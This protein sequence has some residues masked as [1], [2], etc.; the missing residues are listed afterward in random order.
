MI[1]AY[2]FVLQTALAGIAVSQAAAAAAPSSQLPFV[3]CAEHASAPDSLP[4]QPAKQ[5]PCEHC[6]A[7]VI[8]AVALPT[9]EGS[10]AFIVTRAAPLRIVSAQ[11]ASP[12]RAWPIGPRTSQGPPRI[13]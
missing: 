5:A 9:P 10:A 2:V 6:V 4:D 12:T 13:A 8:A 7:C 1:A 11:I 3:L